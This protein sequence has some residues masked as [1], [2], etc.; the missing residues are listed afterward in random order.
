MHTAELEMLKQMLELIQDHLIGLS[1]LT[2]V[3]ATATT[4]L[5]WA[6]QFV[7][8]AQNAIINAQRFL[9]QD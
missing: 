6:Q 1:Q 9:I 2:D 7:G 4:E 5:D 8:R 3:N